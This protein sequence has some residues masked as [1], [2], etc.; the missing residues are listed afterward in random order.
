MTVCRLLVNYAS[1]SGWS[2][3]GSIYMRPE[4][5]EEQSVKCWFLMSALVQIFRTETAKQFQPIKHYYGGVW[6]G[7][8]ASTYS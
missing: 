5:S 8:N 4:F 7:E 2:R 3:L 6:R 1:R